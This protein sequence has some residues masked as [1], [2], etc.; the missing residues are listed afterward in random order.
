MCPGPG[1][2]NQKSLNIRE[3]SMILSLTTASTQKTVWDCYNLM[4]LKTLLSK[5]DNHTKV[6]RELVGNFFKYPSPSSY[7]VERISIFQVRSIGHLCTVVFGR[8][9]RYPRLFL[10]GVPKVPKS[11]V[12]MLMYW[13]YRSVRYR[14]WGRTQPTEVLVPIWSA[15]RTM[16][17]VLRPY[18]TTSVG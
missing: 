4:Y 14:Y 12:P 17:R 6:H 18:R 1:Q 9:Y 16:S 15:Y 11:W 8:V 3:N 2:K 5:N 7:R 13:T 10:V